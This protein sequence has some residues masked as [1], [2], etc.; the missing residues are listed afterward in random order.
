M[1]YLHIQNVFQEYIR[2]EN[3][4][5]ALLINGNW[6]T[7]KTFF[8]ESKLRPI[9]EKHNK[10]IAYVTLNGC[11]KTEHIERDIIIRT[12]P[13]LNNKKWTSPASKLLGNVA[14][15]ASKYFLKTNL[16]DLFKGIHLDTLDLSDYLLVFDDLERCKLHPSEVLGFINSFVEHKKGA[17]V[18]FLAD[19][20]K[21]DPKEKYDEIKEKVIGRV[22][23]FKPDIEIT[24]QDLINKFQNDAKF[25]GFL[26]EKSTLLLS[27]ISDYEQNNL[28]AISFLIDNISNT[29][30]FTHIQKESQVIQDEIIIALTVF[31]F[32]FKAGD[33]YKIYSNTPHL[34]LTNHYQFSISKAA[35]E[36]ENVSE[37]PYYLFYKKFIEKRYNQFFFYK[38]L[39]YFAF[40]GYFAIDELKSDIRNR[41]PTEL[42]VEEDAL[43]KLIVRHN[44]L[45]LEDEEFE[46]Y[47]TIVLEAAK[48]GVYPLQDYI[49]LTDWLYFF[50]ENEII[51]LTSPQIDEIIQKGIAIAKVRKEISPE[52]IENRKHFGVKRKEAQII[53]QQI[54][55]IYQEI[56]A[57]NHSEIGNKFLNSIAM[58]DKD[59]MKKMFLTFNF[60]LPIFKYVDSKHLSNTI[61]TC[62][63]SALD[64][65]IEQMEDRY[66]HGNIDG[67]Y[68]HEYDSLFYLSESIKDHLEKEKIGPVKKIHLRKLNV[69]LEKT[70]SKLNKDDEI[71]A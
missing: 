58:T 19:E 31:S 32:T 45:Q 56:L 23:E 9:A 18:L 46:K 39:Y 55:G 60:T 33:P 5:Y 29:D 53:M 66:E 28:R 10:K 49:T 47:L 22:L 35:R 54:D 42:S 16:S 63:N 41:N 7:G 37:N 62:S 24:F 48:K 20:S 44:Y 70:C 3:T 21:I 59:V 50:L 6:G 52:A 68:S 2:K 61:L 27:L 51:T 4:Q 57:E 38:S 40:T 43:K 69:L 26:K 13:R 1:T 15:G 11:S 71:K 8:Y 14:D 65:F 30:L 64:Y 36:E 34:V 12:I 67:I 17:K 25:Y